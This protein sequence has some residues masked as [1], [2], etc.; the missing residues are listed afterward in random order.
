WT[1]STSPTASPGT[2]TSVTWCSSGPTCTWSGGATACPTARGGWPPSRPA[3]P[4]LRLPPREGGSGRGVVACVRRR[5]P[6]TSHNRTVRPPANAPGYPDLR[7]RGRYVL[8]DDDAR[9]E[10]PGVRQVERPSGDAVS[11]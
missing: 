10:P 7:I 2:S 5:M 9:G 1:S 6:R 4:P 11:E 3:T 8:Q